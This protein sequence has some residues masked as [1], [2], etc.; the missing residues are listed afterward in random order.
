MASIHVILALC[1]PYGDGFQF[2]SLVNFVILQCF[3]IQPS[4]FS[5]LMPMCSSPM[6]FQVFPASNLV[7]FYKTP[8]R[9]FVVT[10]AI[11][12]HRKSQAIDYLARERRLCTSLASCL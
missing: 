9:A 10:V 4:S 2:F 11:A 12:G 3:Q 7:A 1:L 6:I 8:S 5:M